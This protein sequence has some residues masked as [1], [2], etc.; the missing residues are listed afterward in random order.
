MESNDLLEYIDEQFPSEGFSWLPTD[1]ASLATVDQLLTLEDEL[2]IHLRVITMGFLLP[3]VVARKSEKEL[4]AYAN[5]G[6][7]DPYR[8]K[9]IEW[10]RNFGRQGVTHEQALEAVSAFHKAFSKLDEL[11]SD[12]AWLLGDKPSVLDIAWFITLHRADLAGY[13]LIEHRNLHRVYGQMCSR[14]AFQ[15]ELKKGPAIVHFIGPLYR[16]I[17]KT[18]GTTLRYYFDRWKKS[19]TRCSNGSDAASDAGAANDLVGSPRNSL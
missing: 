2:H 1:S 11:V 3:R 19:T 4:E 8:T 7:D 12:Q 14:P 13:P 5:N 16:F 9:Q 18:R 17:R 15:Q 6:V 10:W